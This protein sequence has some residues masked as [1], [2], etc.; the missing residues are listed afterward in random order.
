MCV[1]VCVCVYYADS[2]TI[3]TCVCVSVCVCD[4]DSLTS[5]ESKFLHIW[6]C[7]YAVSFS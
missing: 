6:H 7:T 1:C 4:T 2:L 5:M 3:Y